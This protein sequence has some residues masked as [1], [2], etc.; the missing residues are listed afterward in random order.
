M[1]FGLVGALNL[2]AEFDGLDFP[3]LFRGCAI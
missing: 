2:N 3:R 1:G